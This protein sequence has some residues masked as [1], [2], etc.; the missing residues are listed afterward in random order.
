M[1]LED[2]KLS[3]LTVYLFSLSAVVR[4]ERARR[5]VQKQKW[6][7]RRSEDAATTPWNLWRAWWVRERGAAD[8]EQRKRMAVLRNDHWTLLMNILPYLSW[9][10]SRTFVAHGRPAQKHVACLLT[11]RT[12]DIHCEYVRTPSYE[13]CLCNSTSG[14]KKREKCW[15]T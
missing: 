10:L 9:F 1:Q 12:Q 5:L 6:R 3:T 2:T 13:L 11:L 8:S 7:Q 4:L 14:I 15:I